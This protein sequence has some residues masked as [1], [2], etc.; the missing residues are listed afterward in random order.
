MNIYVFHLLDFT[1]NAMATMAIFAHLCEYF[2]RVKRN[3][4][5]FRYYFVPRVES[6]VNRF[7]II[8]WMSRMAR[9]I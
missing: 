2:V 8:G 4:D 9:R 7:G 6:K 5:L 1:P 3:V